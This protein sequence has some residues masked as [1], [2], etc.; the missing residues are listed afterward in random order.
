[1]IKNY[2][3][4]G[5]GLGLPNTADDL[6]SLGGRLE[7]ATG[8]TPW[9]TGT[10]TGPARNHFA[11]AGTADEYTPAFGG[12][13]RGF[14]IQAGLDPDGIALPG[15]PTERALDATLNSGGAA[16]DDV[17]GF[18]SAETGGGAARI[19]H[20]PTRP[21][22]GGARRASA[23][24]DTAQKS[25]IRGLSAGA[26]IDGKAAI[27]IVPPPA[28]RQP[29][30]RGAANASGDRLQAQRTLSRVGFAPRVT[31]QSATGK[32]ISNGLRAYQQAKGL[33]ADGLMKPGGPTERRLHKQIKSQQQALKQ[34]W[35]E[36][37][38]RVI[39]EARAGIDGTEGVN[40]T[41]SAKTL[42]ARRIG[43]KLDAQ[44]TETL[45]AVAKGV[46]QRA[47]IIPVAD[48][49]EPGTDARD[50]ITRAQ[51][52]K[53]PLAD[54]KPD[55]GSAEEAANAEERRKRNRTLD[56]RTQSGQPGAF[57]PVFD[58]VRKAHLWIKDNK[59][60]PQSRE[61]A[62]RMVGRA[63]IKAGLQVPDQ[64]ALI[65]LVDRKDF[66]SKP[67]AATNDEIY[68]RLA[69]GKTPAEAAHERKAA[70]E[71]AEMRKHAGLGDVEHRAD[72]ESRFAVIAGHRLPKVTATLYFRILKA[73]KEDATALHHQ[74]SRAP[75]GKF[76]KSRLRLMLNEKT[77]GDGKFPKERAESFLPTLSERERRVE[78][79]RSSAAHFMPGAGFAH[80]LRGRP[81]F[82]KRPT[83]A[84]QADLHANRKRE[85]SADRPQDHILQQE[86]LLLSIPGV[87]R[88]TSQ[89]IL[90]RMMDMKRNVGRN[91]S[92]DDI[93]RGALDDLPVASQKR[94]KAA[95]R[96]FLGRGGEY[97]VIKL[98]Q[99]AGA[100]G[101]VHTNRLFYV[102]AVRFGFDGLM[103]WRI[104]RADGTSKRV[105]LVKNEAGMSTGVEVKT[106]SGAALTP[107]Q[108][109]GHKAINKKDRVA[110]SVTDDDPVTVN[111]AEMLRQDFHETNLK[112]LQRSFREGFKRQGLLSPEQVDQVMKNL[113]ILHKLSRSEKGI[114][115]AEVIAFT[116]MSAALVAGADKELQ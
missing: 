86:R 106:G 96:S 112:E 49:P 1:M 69:G 97:S 34:N 102:T 81:G 52:R 78:K 2:L 83:T 75:L 53:R 33:K 10:D 93:L 76:Q 100:E 14:Q 105:K 5:I 38:D 19:A 85:S 116:I 20:R 66:A 71:A 45:K 73:R 50:G 18:A 108:R 24:R 4:N 39:A 12:A 43:A 95:V 113:A 92:V 109:V 56:A 104:R 6:A 8:L 88:A 31:E 110:N 25:E 48:G 65:A 67:L 111:R 58:T 36:E 15:G 27:P 68:R 70:L 90:N 7:R 89:K 61:E 23:I 59:G 72:K 51:D 21:K 91:P 79:L 98:L 9:M 42:A 22:D 26:G 47:A 114:S 60:S 28:I 101:A 62:K 44:R 32:A 99:M 57:R 82:G 37:V 103:N 107:N 80:G 3:T 41:D 29:V 40:T 87:R 13:I 94:V 35:A 30:G 55:P 17:Y 11:E 54:R 77:S 16:A 74:I 84:A 46:N 115:T 64:N 63:A